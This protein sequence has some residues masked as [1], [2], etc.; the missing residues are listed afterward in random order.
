M[1]YN[2][3]ILKNIEK[4]I[5]SDLILLIIWGRQVGK[6]TLLKEINKKIN[7]KI[8]T[9]FLN[10]ENIGIKNLLNINPEN[11]FQ[12]TWS[13]KDTKQIIF[14][15]EIQYLDNPTNFLKYIYDEYKWII[16][17][18]ITWSRAF[19]IDSK[20]KDSLIWRKKIF[21]MYWLD[22]TE[23]LEFQWRND[24]I[25]IIETHKR[26]PLLLEKDIEKI[27]ME[28]I[29]YWW[30]PQIAMLRSKEYK[31]DMLNDYCND[32]IKKDI[33]ESRIQDEVKFL[34]LIKILSFQ[35]WNLL[36]INEIANTLDSSQPTIE[37]FIYVLQKTF[38]ISLIRPFFH[39]IRNELSKM[40]KIYFNDLWIRNSFLRN[41][42][43]IHDRIDKW[44]YLEN[45]VFR[46]FLFKYPL[47]EIKFRRTQS[48]NE[49]DF[50]I[51]ENQAY[52]IK[53]D[54]KWISQSKYKVFKENYKNIALEFIWFNDVMEMMY[55]NPI[56]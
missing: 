34:N 8:E 15:D 1:F 35:V 14:I 32:Y 9:Y 10:L 38:H 37:K 11:I 49:I 17:L 6:T 4:H 55:W 40:P 43:N 29:T 52:E 51:N 42:D 5:D 44:Q 16:K 22:F 47:D 46:E 39:N 54:K 24:L 19:Y 30:Y 7:R 31:I 18:I 50:I 21:N 2:R 41:F 27:W 3:K 56:I 36:N 26:I 13:W 23:Y 20:F 53:F 48:K 33:Y 28:Y 25:K 45:L 12:I